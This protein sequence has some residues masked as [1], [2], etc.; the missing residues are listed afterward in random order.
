MKKSTLSLFFALFLVSLTAQNQ[1]FLNLKHQ[2]GTES[3]AL[4]TMVT[5]NAGYDLEITR[6]QYYV[7]EITIIHDGGQATMIEDLYLLVNAAQGLEYDLGEH[8]ITT[9]EKI[10]FS[11]GVDEASNHLDP[12]SFSLSHPLAPQ[13]PTMHWGWT[14]GYRFVAIGGNAGTGLANG[15]EIHAL[16]DQNYKTVSLTTN[17]QANSNNEIKINV[18]ADYLGLFTNLDVSNGLDIHGDA[19]GAVTLLENM[20]N[21]VFTIDETVTSTESPAFAGTF[22]ISPNPATAIG[23]TIELDLPT[24]ANYQITVTDLAG[25]VIQQATVATGTQKF[26]LQASEAG[27]YLVHLWQNNA[28]VAVKKW[29]IT[30]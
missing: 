25:R 5:S 28:P 3:F 26:P 23:S 24:G 27:V 12:A 19:G 8:A 14:A 7:S 9:V 6:L 11:I 29:L 20:Q 2:L 16:G 15:Y 17:T 4:N 18:A 22:E 30:E 21:E 13:N 10:E 1:V